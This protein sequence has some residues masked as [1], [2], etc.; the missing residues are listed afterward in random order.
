M[1]AVIDI[2]GVNGDEV[3]I[4]GSEAGKEG[5]WLATKV[6]GLMDP[7]V[8]T[9]SKSPGNRPGSRYVSHRILERTLVFRV[10]IE[11]DQNKS[12]HKT[13]VRWRKLWAYDLYTRIRV[14]TEDGSRILK[15][16]LSEIEVDTEYD[17]HV[18]DATDVVMTVV[19]DDPFWYGEELVYD[20]RPDTKVTITNANPTGNDVYPVWVLQAPGQ[21]DIPDFG[22]GRRIT[23]P[24]LGSGE[25][26][27]VDT[28]PG[29][30]QLMSVT[31]TPVWNR[32]NG[33]RFRGK[34]EPYMTDS[35]QISVGGPSGG[36]AQLRIPRP[37]NRP[38]GDI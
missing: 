4:A 24:S 20:V 34:I 22:E 18:N 6:E 19:A 32:M 11:N 30:R 31:D 3:C 17:P 13:D 1:D 8:S 26:T 10:T 35:F 9:V 27:V 33:V 28:D 5:I 7:E 23:L 36:T 37:Y 16:R 2:L 15:A 14:T 25:H 29:S 38:W 21:W 12:W